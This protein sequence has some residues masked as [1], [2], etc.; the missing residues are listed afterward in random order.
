MAR[1]LNTQSLKIL[2]YIL[3]TGAKE[4]RQIFRAINTT[5]DYKDFYN[6]VYRLVNLELLQK[7]NTD[8]KVFELTQ[9]G[10]KTLQ[11]LKPK[12]DGI[13]KIVIFDIPEKHKY[14]RSVLRAKLKALG[15]KKWQN[16]IWVS[17]Y[18]LDNE[19]EQEMLELSKKFFVRLIKTKE[20]NNTT[21]LEKM[22]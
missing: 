10:L 1:K 20:I 13:W 4:I 21:D 12:K 9:E 6:N 16:S 15:F 8:K 3:E 14:I 7:S 2:E 11:R 5:E 17:P 19:I 18:L 22:F